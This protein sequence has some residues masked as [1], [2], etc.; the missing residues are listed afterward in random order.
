MKKAKRSAVFQYPPV[1]F[2][3]LVILTGCKRED[4]ISDG[5][6]SVPSV[7]IL[8]YPPNDTIIVSQSLTFSWMA[9]AYAESY[10]LQISKSNSFISP[11][12]NLSGI[13]NTIKQVADLEDSTQYFWRVRASNSHGLSLWSDPVRSFTLNGKKVTGH[14]C[15]GISTVIYAG[16][17]YNTVLIGHQCWLRENLDIGTMIYYGQNSMNNGT[18]EKYCYYDLPEN[19]DTYG[20]LYRWDEA[21]NYYTMEKSQG[22][23]PAGWHIPS[24]SEF[25][26]LANAVS[27]DGNALKEI[28]EGTG[29]DA[30]TNTSGF[31]A[32]L[33]GYST[34]EEDFFFLDIRGF[35]WSSTMYNT[36]NIQ[37]TNLNHNGSRIYFSNTL[38]EYGFSI[39][40]IKDQDLN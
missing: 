32:L 36:I 40:C 25:Q 26:T 9:P 19:C 2:I 22:I 38:K 23:C 37:Y 20:G 7:P 21:M 10:I 1:I 3:L 13:T 39:R 6:N 34:P 8:L 12:Y 16:R 15:P 30:G 14:P 27:N 35:F 17:T 24:Y 31:S 11:E 4:F 5:S 28:G 18:V 29:P 33:A